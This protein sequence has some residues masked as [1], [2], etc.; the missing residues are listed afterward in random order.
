MMRSTLLLLLLLA[1]FSGAQAQEP[2]LIRFSH[3]VSVEGPKGIGA[4]MVRDLVAERMGD[5]V[6]VEVYPGSE[7]FTDEQ[8]LL[9]LLTGDVQLAAPSLSKFGEITTQLQAFDLPFLFDDVEAAQRFQGSETGRKLLDSM[10][11]KGIKGL[12]YWDNGMRVVSATRELRTPDDLNDLKF[13]IEASD[14]IEE[15]YQMMDALPLKLPFGQVRDA[16][17]S[18]LVDGQENS[19]SNIASQRFYTLGQQFTETE[20]SYLGYMVVTSVAF[21]EALPQDIRAGLE[22][23]IAEVT[24]EVNRIARDKAKSGRQQVVDAGATVIEF[25]PHEKNAWVA[26]W[27]PL[28]KEFEDSIGDD[29]VFVAA[30]AN[31]R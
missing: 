28:W 27:K 30:A 20:H 1:T 11:A 25:S 16:L 8:V 23:I 9:A 26:Q 12:A 6:R 18:G 7:L 4:E 17:Q 15:Q 24:E 5:K 31:Q 21:W 22:A 19:W 10:V 13:R 14:V 3:M 2:I 29:I